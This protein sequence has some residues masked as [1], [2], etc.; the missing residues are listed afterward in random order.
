MIKQ[1]SVTLK[2][3]RALFTLPFIPECFHTR[4]IYIISIFVHSSLIVIMSQVKI[5]LVLLI[6]FRLRMILPE[7][8]SQYTI[9]YIVEKSLSKS[10]FLYL[11]Y[12]MVKIFQVKL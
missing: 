5:K 3:F 4:R 11:Q 7:F 12:C 8:K 10:K 1:H 6:Q 2:S 9:I